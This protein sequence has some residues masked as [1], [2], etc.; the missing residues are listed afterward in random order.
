MK[1]VIRGH[2]GAVAAAGT[3]AAL[4]EGVGRGGDDGVGGVAGGGGGGDGAA[5]ADAVKALRSAESVRAVGEMVW[6]AEPSRVDV[7]LDKKG[8]CVG[9][10]G[11]DKRGSIEF[12]MRGDTV[13]LK[14]DAAYLE[15]EY[16]YD[17]GMIAEVEGSYLEESRADTRSA[18]MDLC[19]LDTYVEETDSV[20]SF[21]PDMTLKETTKHKG[22]AVVSYVN[23]NPA[24]SD[25]ASMKIAAEGKPYPVTIT[26]PEG[27]EVDLAFSAFGEPVGAKA[28]AAESVLTEDQLMDIRLAQR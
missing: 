9:E 20:V 24:T 14:P 1:Q 21:S 15:S 2:R 7:R 5:Q 18:I 10:A 16:A 3:A 17:A 13:W 25:G 19:S 12:V 27:T 11:N 8:D 26:D 23:E 4:L 28:P 22:V 6:V